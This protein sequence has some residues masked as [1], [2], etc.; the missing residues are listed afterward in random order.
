M[1]VVE[2][3]EEAQQMRRVIHGHAVYTYQIVPR[4]A[5]VHIQSAIQFSGSSNPRQQLK[6]FYRITVS[7]HSR[8]KIHCIRVKFPVSLCTALQHRSFFGSHYFHFLNPPDGIGSDGITVLCLRLGTYICDHHPRKQYKY[9][10][11]HV[12]LLSP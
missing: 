6:G 9:I 12:H 11:Y 1:I 10:S 3:R 2:D 4:F 5:A 8:Q 7:Q